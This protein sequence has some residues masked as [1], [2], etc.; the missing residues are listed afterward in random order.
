M[1]EL[2]FE[3]LSKHNVLLTN[4]T[5]GNQIFTIEDVINGNI[6]ENFDKMINQKNIDNSRNKFLDSSEYETM[7]VN[8]ARGDSSF[9]EYVNSKNGSV[10]EL[11]KGSFRNPYWKKKYNNTTRKNEY[12][13]NEDKAKK[14][15]QKYYEDIKKGINKKATSSFAG[16]GGEPA[17][18]MDAFMMGVNQGTEE[19][20]GGMTLP[21][22]KFIYDHMQPG[23]SQ[24]ANQ[25][26]NHIQDLMNKFDQDIIFTEG[27]A[28]AAGP[29]SPLWPGN[30]V[31]DKNFRDKKLRSGDAKAFFNMIMTQ[32]SLSHANHKGLKLDIQYHNISGNERLTGGDSLDDMYTAYVITTMPTAGKTT[33]MTDEVEEE[34][35]T[36]TVLVPRKKDNNP[37]MYGNRVKDGYSV[38]LNNFG[39]YENGIED[40]GRF[41]VYKDSKDNLMAQITNYAWDASTNSVQPDD[42]FQVNLAQD[43]GL[44]QVGLRGLIDGWNEKFYQQQKINWDARNKYC[45]ACQCCNKN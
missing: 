36:I 22:Y 34:G 1:S 35:K 31:K 6:P 29:G 25:Q 21:G 30:W 16:P 42:P 24:I 18:N 19:T 28:S 4:P 12:V 11:Q 45:V 8:M 20:P 9:A 41:M 7:F 27:D 38:Y 39:T 40:G 15:A 23:K 37:Y 17:F 10:Q 43:Y 13:F 26:L 2:E 14:D 44:N 3:L 5:S 33:G 32:K